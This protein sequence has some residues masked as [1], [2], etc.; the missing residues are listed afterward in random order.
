MTDK[1][2]TSGE[3]CEKL[4]N[5]CAGV[6]GDTFYYSGPEWSR[7]MADINAWGFDCLVMPKSILWGWCADRTDRHGGAEYGSHGVY[8][9]TEDQLIERCEPVDFGH[10]V[11]ATLLYMK[12]HVGI[13]V[14]SVTINGVEGNVI[15]STTDGDSCVQLT[16]M[17]PDG[18]RYI[19]DVR[20]NSWERAGLLPYLEYNVIEPDMEDGPEPVAYEHPASGP[21]SLTV[22]DI[23]DMIIAGEFDNG[24]ERK[25]KLYRFFQDLVNKRFA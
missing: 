6:Y 22:A 8:D 3:F 14:G 7:W 12:G 10:L 1:V 18:G 16:T 4:I 5:I 15:E 17:L 23:I 9:D 24:A 19:G 20:C 21:E 2:M 13:Y 11:P 25:E